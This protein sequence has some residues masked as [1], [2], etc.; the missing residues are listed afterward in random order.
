MLQPMFLNYLETRE[1]IN[2]DPRDW[3]QLVKRNGIFGIPPMMTSEKWKTMSTTEK[4]TAVFG[5]QDPSKRKFEDVPYFVR[6]VSREKDGK[7]VYC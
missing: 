6:I 5:P 2:T 1:K 3:K 7:C 4:Y